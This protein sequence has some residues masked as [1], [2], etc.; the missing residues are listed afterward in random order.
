MLQCFIY[1]A[2]NFEES[3]LLILTHIITQGLLPFKILPHLTLIQINV[4]Q[5]YKAEM[6]LLI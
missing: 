1:Y 3:S 6:Q 5:N 4:H 2:G